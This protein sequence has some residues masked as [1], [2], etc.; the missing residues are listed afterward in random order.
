M[1]RA[2]SEEHKRKGAPM[3][4]KPKRPMPVKPRTPAQRAHTAAYAKEH[5]INA[6]P[7]RA[8]LP[9]GSWWTEARTREEFDAAAAR[10]GKRMAS[11]KWGRNTL[12]NN[13]T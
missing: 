13:I 11:S 5:V 4:T 3:G 2:L 10:E 8:G 12:G 9:T 7:I 1:S 6:V